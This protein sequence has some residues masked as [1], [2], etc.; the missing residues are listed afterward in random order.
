MASVFLHGAEG[1]HNSF[2]LPQKLLEPGHRNVF[3]NNHGSPFISSL[4]SII[5]ITSRVFSLTLSIPR[6][7]PLQAALSSSGQ[8]YRGK[9][10]QPYAQLPDYLPAHQVSWHVYVS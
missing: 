10:R 6:S 1:K 4:C 9:R 5:S 2:G 7:L 3:E 8:I